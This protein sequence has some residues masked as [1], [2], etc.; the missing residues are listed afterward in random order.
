MLNVDI[1]EGDL[2]VM[3]I[4]TLNCREKML[5]LREELLFVEEDRLQVAVAV[6]LMNSIRTSMI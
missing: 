6:P 2:V 5:K 3:D 1:A 4:E